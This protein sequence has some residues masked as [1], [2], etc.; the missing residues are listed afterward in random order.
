MMEGW[1]Q[2]AEGLW[3]KIKEKQ[4]TNKWRPEVEEEYEDAE[5]N[6]FDRKT[7][8]ELQRQGLI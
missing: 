1:F 7:F 4:G 3:E 6:V 2:D 8:T 5:G